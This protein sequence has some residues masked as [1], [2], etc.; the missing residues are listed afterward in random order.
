[1][2]KTLIKKQ[3]MEVFAWVYQDKKT[4]KNRTKKGLITYV[5]LYLLIFGFL[6]VMF[7]KVAEIL[8]APLV[9]AGVSWLYMALMGLVGV[10]FG[11][12]GSVFNTFAS[13]YQAKDND[14]LLSMPLKPRQILMARLSGVYEMGL[15]Y[16]L[17]VMI[18]VMIV[19]FREAK[20]VLSGMIFCILLPFILSIFVLTLS[21]VL[22][23]IVA[24]CNSRLKN[25]KMITVFISLLFM[26]AYIYFC[27]NVSNLLQSLL[28]EPSQI[29]GKVKGVLYPFYQMG[30]A[31][32]GKP[33][34]MLQF[35]AMVLVLFALVYLILQRSF[36]G[37]ATTKTGESKTKYVEK[38]T[39]VRSLEQTLLQKEFRRFLQSPNYMLNCGLG[40]VFMPVGAVL[41]LVKQ[42][43]IT[44][45]LNGPLAGYT[46]RV[47]LAVIALICSVVS[48]ND[49][50][51]PSVSL[52]GK[53][54]WLLQVLPVS[55]WQV[56]KAKL[57]MHIILTL[58]PAAVLIVAV[59]WI[60]KPNIVWLLL[61]P[62]SVVV[63]SFVMAAFGLACNLKTPNLSWTSENV[64]LKQSMSVMVTLFGGWGVVILFA[65]VYGFVSEYLTAIQ[66]MA[67]CDV[68]LL[69][70]GIV[71]FSWIKKKGAAIFET[72]C[73]S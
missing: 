42:D 72:L 26:G 65:V 67:V 8:C 51:A 62:L 38:K 11:V 43:V 16:E 21:C 3:M 6:G 1:M 71:L 2:T 41:L 55:G 35:S 13:L 28:L 68:L 39:R 36:L 25:K 61:I 5:L 34:A 58:L 24:L 50:S 57:K 20:P 37:L 53:N 69:A 23:W 31:A 19:Y 54:I 29:A 52:E 49:M 12:F 56:L 40:I 14:L 63:F 59:E 33:F 27:G 66:F 9:Q 30:L 64:P 10:T 17:L 32:E 4:G 70:A 45:Y 15:M 7:Y 46:E 22:G 44:S 18:P 73:A 48:M 47:C 60:L